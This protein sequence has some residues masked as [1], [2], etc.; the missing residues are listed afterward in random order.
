[1]V[2]VVLWEV[3]L[4]VLATSVVSLVTSPETALAPLEATVAVVTVAVVVTV[5]P[6]AATTAVVWATSLWNAHLR[7]LGLAV[8]AVVLRMCASTVNNLD[9]GPLS[10][11]TRKLSAHP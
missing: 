2:V 10:A 1:V 11:P 6:R 9:T 7:K 5:L 4:L 3:R 8:V